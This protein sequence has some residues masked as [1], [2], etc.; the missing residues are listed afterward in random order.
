MPTLIEYAA[1]LNLNSNIHDIS[2]E[3][4]N[5]L[6]NNFR[7]IQSENPIVDETTGSTGGVFGK[8]AIL[9][10]LAQSNCIGMRYYFAVS[11]DED[12][13]D[14]LTLVLCGVDSSFNDIVSVNG[15]QGRIL[16]YALPCPTVCAGVNDLN[17][18][19]E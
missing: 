16:E 2:T 17:R 14:Y 8:N 9:S 13:N 18:S 3:D 6:I 19:N 7:D 1:I 11:K 10:L 5:E 4:A 12:D 15:V